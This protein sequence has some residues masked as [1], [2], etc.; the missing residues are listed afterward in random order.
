MFL[1]AFL[2][3]GARAARHLYAVLL[4][5]ISASA[6]SREG[7]HWREGPDVGGTVSLSGG[8]QPSVLKHLSGALRCGPLES[9][10]GDAPL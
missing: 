7:A 6:S 3:I 1:L 9:P 8:T 10:F 4:E 5:R 2:S